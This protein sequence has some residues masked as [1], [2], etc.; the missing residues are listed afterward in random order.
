MNQTL[1]SETGN[2]DDESDSF[3]H[4]PH[5]TISNKETILQVFASELLENL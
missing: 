1:P 4:D 3:V 5:S 2:F